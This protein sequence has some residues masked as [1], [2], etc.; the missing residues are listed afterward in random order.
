MIMKHKQVRKFFTIQLILSI[1]FIPLIYAEDG[2]GLG[3]LDKS[4]YDDLYREAIKNDPP[5]PPIPLDRIEKK[6]VVDVIEKLGGRVVLV[7]DDGS[8]YEPGWSRSKMLSADTKQREYNFTSPIQN[9][10]KDKQVRPRY[11]NS[12]CPGGPP[13]IPNLVGDHCITPSGNPEQVV[14]ETTAPYPPPL[15]P[16]PGYDYVPSIMF[17]EGK[18]KIWWCANTGAWGDR[19]NYVEALD[20]SDPLTYGTPM[21]VFRGTI[22][23]NTCT[24]DSAFDCAHTCDPSVIKMDGYYF[25]FYG[26]FPVGLDY[27]AVARTKVGLAMS[28]DGVNWSR[29][30]GD[31]TQAGIQPIIEPASSAIFPVIDD[32]DYDN[33]LDTTDIVYLPMYGVGQPSVVFKDKKF[34]L[35][36]SDDTVPPNIA[37]IANA[38]VWNDI[39][40][41]GI[42]DENELLDKISEYLIPGSPFYVHALVN[43]RGQ[44]ALKS[45]DVVFNTGLE[46]WQNVTGNWVSLPF[47]GQASRVDSY[48]HNAVGVDWSYSPQ[49]KE[50]IINVSGVD[51]TPA[52]DGGTHTTVLFFNDQLTAQTRVPVHAESSWTEGPGIAKKPNGQMI[53]SPDCTNFWV[54]ILRSMD[55]YYSHPNNKS[56]WDLAHVGWPYSTG[57]SRCSAV[58]RD[59]DGD[60][61]SDQAIWRPHSTN[62]T[63]YIKASST[64]LITKVMGAMNDV[65][66]QGDFDGDG[67]V[68]Y[69]VVSDVG[70]FLWW[71]VTKSTSGTTHTQ[72][73]WGFTGDQIATADFNGDG[74]DEFVIFRNGDWYSI[75]I[76]GM[77]ATYAFGMLGDIAVPSDFD[78]DGKDDLVL[79]RPSNGYWYIYNIAT[80]QTQMQQFGLT[81]D[82]PLPTDFT[83]DGK[84][85]YVVW[86][87]STGYWYISDSV[88]L[89][90]QDYQW[91]LT[92]DVPVVGDF[93]SDNSLDLT[94]W[95]NG[96]GDWFH[97]DMNSNMISVQFGLPGDKV[98]LPHY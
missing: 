34:H 15:T 57:L 53:L 45:S 72:P 64:G 79:Y 90:S 35:T 25:M 82:I 7:L 86:R 85:D 49:T 68:D 19:I 9:S 36:V 54:N 21:E 6:E 14:I 78:G 80:S 92:G 62:S 27:T 83:R 65:P 60:G 5:I 44:Y 61:M 95:R 32:T 1:F 18:Y 48:L 11:S 96:T 16:G 12:I 76:S 10:E 24:V 23:N 91:G 20:I 94:V 73:T 59:F 4:S 74:R 93:F 8:S 43:T 26:G 52:I 28:A 56:K 69:G 98:H 3:F 31:P 17:D 37:A 38:K 29:V 63:H 81:G 58:K 88:S 42:V 39:N 22:A 97:N 89:N 66:I 47:N 46:E 71:T 84:A 70:G 41:D 40:G 50:F 87:P 13:P 75:D 55:P 77:I 2:E 67:T 30:D 51:A 33:D